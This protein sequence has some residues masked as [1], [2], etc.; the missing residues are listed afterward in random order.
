MKIIK[1]ISEMQTWSNDTRRKDQT[2]GFVPTMGFLHEG[3]LSLIRLIR[4][5]C[6]LLVVS[7][8][9]NPTQFGPGEDLAKYPRD[10]KR[11]EVLCRE[12]NVDVIFYP[13]VQE[14]Y[15]TPYLTYVSVESLDKKLCGVSRPHHFRGVLTVVAKL[16]NIV[17]PHRA[18]FGEKD[19]QQAVIIKQMVKDLNFDTD[20]LTGP[21]V[22]E[23]DGL[24]LSSRNKY[25]SEEERKNATIIYKSLQHGRELYRNGTD[26]A[27]E[28]IRKVGNMIEGVPGATVDYVDLVDPLTLQT[29]ESVRPADRLAA[30]VFFG[31]TRLI[32]NIAMG[33]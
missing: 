16:F 12:E 17:K 27:Q 3:H 8:F 30:A 32:D 19:F 7:I 26:N 9:V 13:G 6:D 33:N 10:F 14:M 22:R 24:A 15:S 21:I 31:K 18:I 2:I 11:D 29:R 23:A 28:I 25:L 20:I 4:Q 1:E 5:K